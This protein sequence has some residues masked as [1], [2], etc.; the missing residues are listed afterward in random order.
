MSSKKNP[1]LVQ[2]IDTSGQV[3]EAILKTFLT[4]Y[5][6]PITEAAS[7]IPIVSS[8]V[9]I[10]N[11]Y[12][13]VKE[14]S[15][16]KK[17]WAF[18]NMFSEEEYD[19]FKKIIYTKKDQELGEYIFSALDS[20]SK[21]VQAKMIAKSVKLYVSNC[22]QG[23]DEAAQSIFDYYI[24]VIKN[25]DNYLISGME[26]IYGKGEVDK[27][28]S[29]GKALFNLDLVDQEEKT[30]YISETVPLVTFTTSAKGK[31]FYQNIISECTDN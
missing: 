11:G 8:L 15:F 18:Y 17:F 9:G 26:S 27:L 16:N 7:G 2:S 4:P 29:F 12:N 1:L 20:V 23:N 13:I 10:Y 21:A 25:L 31:D 5:A 30:N 6:G 14:Q 19:S 24:Y 3:T 22:E 28:A